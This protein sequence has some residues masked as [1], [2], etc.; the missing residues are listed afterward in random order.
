MPKK[1]PE[2]ESEEPSL[3]DLLGKSADVGKG[4]L[5]GLVGSI[6]ERFGGPD[7]V[8]EKLYQNYCSL[9]PGSAGQSRILELILRMHVTVHGTLKE[10]DG[11]G[12]L[13]T[14]QLEALWKREVRN[15]TGSDT[16][17]SSEGGGGSKRKRK[18]PSASTGAPA[19]AD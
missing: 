14:E 17:E 10:D 5:E 9:P 2:P 18:D 3:E 12:D 16:S 15:V 4:R 13:E 11:L 1:Q 6:T 19:E 8:A 7:D